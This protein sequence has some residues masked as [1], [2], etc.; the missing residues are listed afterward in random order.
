MAVYWFCS[1][2]VPP[3]QIVSKLGGPLEMIAAIALPIWLLI[4]LPTYMFLPRSSALWRTSVCTTL[5]G[6]AGAL[7]AFVIILVLLGF[8]GVL[9]LWMCILAGAMTG[10]V[11]CWFG[12]ATV[13]YFHN[14]SAT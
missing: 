1:E 14:A 12:A 7:I 6:L 9:F 13:N 11:T 4:L 5:G 10:A 3:E 2:S 8:E